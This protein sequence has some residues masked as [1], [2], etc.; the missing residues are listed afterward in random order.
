MPSPR[1]TRPLRPQAYTIRTL[2]AL[3]KAL[4]GQARR[5]FRADAE[6]LE[7]NVGTARTHAQIA[8]EIL[9]F[10]RTEFTVEH[11]MLLAPALRRLLTLEET[12]AAVSRVFVRAWR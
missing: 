9:R 2:A 7:R 3:R 6:Y 1:N 8:R 10:W 4:D 11:P 5:E 12:S